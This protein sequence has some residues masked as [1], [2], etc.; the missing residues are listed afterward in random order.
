MLES[1][2]HAL[3]QEL[4]EV[5]RKLAQLRLSLP[6]AYSSNFSTP[7]H[8]RRESSLCSGSIASSSS[9]SVGQEARAPGSRSV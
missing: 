6:P 2:L 4:V 8:L 3:T 1:D 5:D 9:L 7:E